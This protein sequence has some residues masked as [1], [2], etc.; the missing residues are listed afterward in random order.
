MPPV[1]TSKGRTGELP[2]G[3]TSAEVRMMLL[4]FTCLDSEIKV[5]IKTSSSVTRSSTVIV[6]FS[7]TVGMTLLSEAKALTPFSWFVCV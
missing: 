1:K 5:R 3:L 2:F 4:A 7:N 6:E